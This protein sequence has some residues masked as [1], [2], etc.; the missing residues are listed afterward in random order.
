MSRPGEGCL[1][2]KEGGVVGEGGRL[3]RGDDEGHS[4]CVCCLGRGE[5]PYYVFHRYFLR[6]KKKVHRLEQKAQGQAE[7]ISLT[8]WSLRTCSVP[9]GGNERLG[10]Q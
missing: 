9:D 1:T 5:R 10:V 6:L 8:P 3:C 7:L 2:E 4:L